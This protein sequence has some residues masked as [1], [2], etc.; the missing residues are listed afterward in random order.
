MSVSPDLT[1]RWF[2]RRETAAVTA[3]SP[4]TTAPG[5]AARLWRGRPGDPA[6]VRPAVLG[7][8][9][10]TAV[11]YTAGLSASG[12]GNAFY[13]AAVQAGSRS[14]EAFFYGSSDAANAITVDKP[15]ASLWVM[16]LSVRIFGLSSWSVLLPQ[17][18]E[19]V[20]AVGVLFAAVRRRSTPAA[21]LLAGAVLALTP[22]AAL[23]FRFDNP[24]ALLVLV[25]VV[26]TWALLRSVDSGRAR[27]LV[28]CGALLGLGFL[29]KQLQ[30]L[31]VLP[32]LALAYLWAAPHPLGRR[33]RHLLL[34]GLALVVAAGWWVAVVEL[35]PASMRPYV[36]GSQDDSILGLTFGYNGFGRLTGEETGS[37]GGGGGWGET[38]I[39]R[40]F[41]SEMGGQ[42]A[43]L[44]PAALLLAAA[45]FVL[46]RRAPRT[47]PHR[48]AYVAWTGWVL[49]TGLTFSFMSGII[50]PYYTVALAP[51][52]AALVGLGAVDL[53]RSRA[54][55]WALPALAGVVLLTA[56][57]S[58]VLLGRT[59][60]FIPWLRAVVLVA[61][62][63][64]A[65]AL[66]AG[67]LLRHRLVPALLRGGLAAAVVAGL[68]GPV[69]Y[70]AQTVS[71]GH[72]G[73]IVS[74]GPTV[75]GAAG[76]RPGAGF[77]GGGPS[78]GRFGGQVGGQAG[79]QGATAAAPPGG[80]AGGFAPGGGPTGVR[81]TGGG[82]G[83]LLGSTTPGADVVALLEADA[84]SYR[85]VLATTGSNNAAGYQLA[86][87]DPVMAVG[88][89]N[90]T[91]PSPTLAQF[92]AHVAAGDIH[93]YAQGR[94]LGGASSTGGTEPAAQ[95]AA[96]VA[97][98]F[99]TT[100]VDG[101]T[102]Y[103]LTQPVAASTALASATAA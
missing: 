41:G 65:A 93:Y 96:W 59:P 18:V 87:Q 2:R 27:W 68:A 69:A 6:W 22:V 70:T 88:G 80:F 62:V 85:W 61:G 95:I 12:W 32:G 15:P 14:W 42:I 43:W 24:D 97:E 21:G 71:T 56:V 84:S 39:A 98:N 44:L 57:W 28:L 63:L 52:V 99:T 35:V 86:T 83:G 81:G 11:L 5:R 29:T 34:G 78:R 45:G 58:A 47:D 91:D 75:A 17:A 23:M 36:G 67:S 9:V 101:T 50:H 53:W 1:G 72:E 37:V 79:G 30:V 92:Q 3:T 38:G 55:R 4:V 60:E 16:A 74:A 102:F 7:L 76:G 19:G 66:V 33:T 10:A 94:S 46:T 73:S 26:A 20:A 90:G 51:G 100:T 48:A 31:L 8:L 103:D 64:G 25:M 13:A 40:L 89:F 82:M 54:R 49:V 77:A